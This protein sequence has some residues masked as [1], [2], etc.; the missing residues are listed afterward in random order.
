M[1]TILVIVVLKGNQF[2]RS[3]ATTLSNEGAGVS[4]KIP[5]TLGC[6]CLRCHAETDR[7]ERSLKLLPRERNELWCV[8]HDGAA[9]SIIECVTNCRCPGVLHR[10]KEYLYGDKLSAI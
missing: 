10:F 2:V 4:R 9:L 6:S 5:C 1:E 3:W 7:V 8:L